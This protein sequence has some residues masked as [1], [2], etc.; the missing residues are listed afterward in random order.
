MTNG[1]KYT[2]REKVVIGGLGALTPLI[3]HLLVVDLQGWWL[4]LAPFVVV[5]AILL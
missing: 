4:T 1:K 5:G 3:L 2:K